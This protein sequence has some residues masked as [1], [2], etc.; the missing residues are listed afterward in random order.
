MSITYIRLLVVAGLLVAIAGCQTGPAVRDVWSTKRLEPISPADEDFFL[1]D[2]ASRIRTTSRLLPVSEQGEQFHVSWHGHAVELVQFEY[3]QL[4]MPDQISTQ[5]F[6]T[7]G[8]HRTSFWIRG[9]AFLKGGSVSAW[10]VTLWNNGDLLA[11]KHS[12][13]W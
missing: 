13:L 4:N 11:E 8:R 5:D 12:T 7:K 6:A 2:R 9:D 10:R 1:S 3:R